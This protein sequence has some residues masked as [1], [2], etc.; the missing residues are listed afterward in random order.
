MQ[1]VRGCVCSNAEKLGSANAALPFASRGLPAAGGVG[2]KLSA[3][4]RTR[5]N[6]THHFQIM[7]TARCKGGAIE[8][9]GRAD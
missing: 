2:R 1:G 7:T 3:V 4:A 5:A 9:Q 8:V 6:I